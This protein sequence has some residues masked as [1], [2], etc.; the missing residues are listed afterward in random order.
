[1]DVKRILRVLIILLAGMSLALTVACG[2]EGEQDNDFN[3]GEPDAGTDADDG[4]GDGGEDPDAGDD[5]DVG[6]DDGDGDLDFVEL[7]DPPPSCADDNP[8]ARCALDPADEGFEF[9]PASLITELALA[10]ASDN[11]CFDFTGDGNNDNS[12]PSILN[13][14]QTSAAEVNETLAESV[15]DGTI[16]LVLEHQ[17]LEEFTELADGIE[18]DIGFLL[19]EHADDADGVYID[20]LAFEEGGHPEAFLPNALITEVGE[21]LL[22]TAGPGTV[23]ITLDLFDVELEL[24]IRNAKIEAYAVASADGLENGVILE[25]G[26]LGGLILF[27]DIAE[28]LNKFMVGCD[29]LDNP[30]PF[31]DASG[32][33]ATCGMSEAQK[34]MVDGCT[35]D[36]DLCGT[37]GGFCDVLGLAPALAA[38]IDTTGDG[39]PD[40]FSAGLFFEAEATVILGLVGDEPDNGGDDPVCTVEEEETDCPEAGEICDEDANECIEADCTVDSHC[41]D[42]QFCDGDTNECV[43][44]VCTAATQDDDCDAGEVCDEAA[45]ECVPE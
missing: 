2:G 42:D 34:E 24:A 23:V 26:I 1:M 3:I 37:I 17:G 43:D 28:A 6:E 38:D 21:D 33:T 13:L 14:A 16:T 41:T 40:A 29:C 8:P 12:L 45:N 15:E 4:D 18:F 39:T 5:P 36:E 32:P 7:A 10:D 35:G 27:T 9:S 31:L 44:V 19:A 11:C 30:D 25:D 20:P 22:V